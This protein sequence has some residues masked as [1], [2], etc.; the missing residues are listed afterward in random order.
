MDDLDHALLTTLATIGGGVTTRELAYQTG[1][2]PQEV[3]ERMHALTADGEADVYAWA[4]PDEQARDLAA[5]C[6]A[7][8]PRLVPSRS[9]APG[10]RARARRRAGE[11]AA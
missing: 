4:T 7:F 1:M 10:V 9:F 2:N 5:A 11:G 8:R 6:A 3:H